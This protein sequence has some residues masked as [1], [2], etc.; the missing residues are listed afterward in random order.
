MNKI[1]TSATKI[2]LLLIV[3]TLCYLA[4]R[5]LQIDPAFKDIALMVFSFY[6]GAKTVTVDKDTTQIG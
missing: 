5:Q 2:T 6:F 3:L 1:Y 4:V